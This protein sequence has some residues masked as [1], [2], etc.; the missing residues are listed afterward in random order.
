M[1]SVSSTSWN[2]L[3]ALFSMYF[4]EMCL[5]LGVLLSEGLF[6]NVRGPELSDRRNGE[7]LSFHQAIF[8]E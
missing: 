5:F 8:P 2:L 4:G 7:H 1:N 3:I 6:R